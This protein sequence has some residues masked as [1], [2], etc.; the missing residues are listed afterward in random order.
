MFKH[1]LLQA[2]VL[3]CSVGSKFNL[4]VGAI[5]NAISKAAGPELQGELRQKTIGRTWGEGDI[6]HTE[7]GH[8][9]CH[10]PLCVLSLER[11]SSGRAGTRMTLTLMLL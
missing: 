4:T 10:H 5:A 9:N 7:A 8:L 1:T 6:V 11:K 2:D 3:V